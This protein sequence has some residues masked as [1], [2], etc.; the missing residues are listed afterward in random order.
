MAWGPA[1][2]RGETRDEPAKAPPSEKKPG[3]TEEPPAAG[4]ARETEPA[5]EEKSSPPTLEK[6]PEKDLPPQTRRKPDPERDVF[7]RFS[8][9]VKIDETLQ[10]STGQ[11]AP[12]ELPVVEN[13]LG[14][15]FRRAGHPVTPTQKGATYV[16]EGAV[17]A[18]FHSTLKFLESTIGWKYRGSGHI[19]V[20]D[21]T[22]KTIERFEVPEVFDES[23]RS[24]AGAAHDLE[25]HIAK[26]FW[27][28]IATSCDPFTN[29]EVRD[30]IGALASAGITRARSGSKD[31]EDEADE[32]LLATS[33]VVRRLADIGFAAVPYLIDALDDERIVAIPA[34]YPGLE[35]KASGRLRVF[36]IADKAL[37]EIFQKVSRMNLEIGTTT[38][39]DIRLRR[40][41]LLGWER[42]W[43]RFCKPFR[44]SP[45]VRK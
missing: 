5:K 15:Y 7:Q 19:E 33:D 40:V 20:K 34:K 37:E 28:H 41:I 26:L 42:E 23:G 11:P 17:E 4:K 35:G 14:E 18:R 43:K 45:N 31:P 30:L 6:I 1:E 8:V 16:I 39:D 29:A 9:Y 44:E 22:G 25:R 13:Y 2:G 36:H 3:A 10:S 38:S 12:P 24:E 32:S 27:D 21:F